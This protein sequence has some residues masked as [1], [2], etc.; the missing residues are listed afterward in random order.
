M[1]STFN[2]RA[3]LRRAYLKPYEADAIEVEVEHPSFEERVTGTVLVIEG[4]DTKKFEALLESC[5]GLTI[6]QIE[7]YEFS[8]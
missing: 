2:S 8:E 5:N 6:E 1:D 3:I 4:W 7:S